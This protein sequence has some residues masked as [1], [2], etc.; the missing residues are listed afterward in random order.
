M[1]VVVVPA[2]PR[3]SAPATTSTASRRRS[4]SVVATPDSQSAP[5]QRQGAILWAGFSPERA[6]A[7]RPRAARAAQAAPAAA[8]AARRST[9]TVDGKPLAA[10]SATGGGSTLR[11]TLRNATSARAPTASARGELR[12]LAARS[13]R[14]RRGDL[15]AR[16][17][18]GHRRA[19]R[20]TP[21]PR[22]SRRRSASRASSLPG[23]PPRGS[24][25]RR[26]H[27]R[28]Q[29]RALLGAARRRPPADRTSSGLPAAAVG[30]GAAEA[31]RRGTDGRAVADARRRRAARRGPRRS[32]S[33]RSSTRG[34]C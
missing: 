9:R 16:R 30:V 19:P 25:G 31:P 3:Q 24:G 32:G 27:A 10:G 15:P 33:T 18:R 4:L 1:S 22:R 14:A 28:R 17:R 11:L 20:S 13:T 26:R 5:G 12:S 2:A 8:A 29:P 34:A 23:R 7:R 21:A 6:A